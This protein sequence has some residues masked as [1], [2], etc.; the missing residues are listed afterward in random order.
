MPFP[1]PKVDWRSILLEAF[2]VVLGVVLALAANEW[3]RAHE[4]RQN[5]AT[6]MASI[7]EELHTHRLAVL[8]S[9]QYHAQLLDTLTSLSRRAQAGNPSSSPPMLP[10]RR[11]FA[12]GFFHPATLL[13]TARDAAAATDAV[14]HMSYADVL[15]LARIYAVQDQYRQQSEQVGQLLYGHLFSHGFGGVLQN[16]A[17]LSTILAAFWYRECQLLHRY[18]DTLRQLDGSTEAEAVAVPERCRSVAAD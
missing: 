11:L 14:R 4:D 3:R 9:V 15:P 8:Q 16:Y 18:E 10:E 13:H 2:F 1:K 12:R 7:R 6:A 17:N 5:A